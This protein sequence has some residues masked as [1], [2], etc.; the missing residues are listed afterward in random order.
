MYRF[1]FVAS[2]LFSLPVVGLE[3]VSD[4]LAAPHHFHVCD[5]FVFAVRRHSLLFLV[6]SSVSSTT[7]EERE[8]AATFQKR[9]AKQHHS[10][11]QRH[12]KGERQRQPDEEKEKQRHPKAGG[13]DATP[14]QK[15]GERHSTHWVLRKAASPTREE[16]EQQHDPQG[17]RGREPHHPKERGGQPSPLGRRRGVT[18]TSQEEEEAPPKKERNTST[19]PKLGNGR[20]YHAKEGG[21]NAAPLPEIMLIRSCC[22]MS[23]YLQQRLGR[24]RAQQRLFRESVIALNS[25]SNSACRA[26][27]NE[28]TLLPS[29]SASPKKLFPTGSQSSVL[30]SVLRSSAQDLHLQGSLL[31]KP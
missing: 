1:F 15:R 16:G 13:G 22:A 9:E 4:F 7:Q 10:N 17:E 30:R 24:K 18:R 26:L 25:L 8:T 21:R 28:S 14:P 29:S 6:S 3:G 5:C 19:P 23:R 12:P 2:L 31:K 27:R 20:Q 11:K